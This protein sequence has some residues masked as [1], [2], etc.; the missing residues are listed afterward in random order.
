M[1]ESPEVL[2][3]GESDGH[4]ER[5]GHSLFFTVRFHAL[6]HSK[7]AS[8]GILLQAQCER[9]LKH[10]FRVGGASAFGIDGRADLAIQSM[11]QPIE[12]ADLSIVDEEPTSVDKGVAVASGNRRTRGGSYVGHE[13]WR[14]DV[15]GHASQILVIPGRPDIMKDTGRRTASV[16]ADPEAIS[17]DFKVRTF[18]VSRLIQNG[19]LRSH[20]N[21]F[22]GE[23][24]TTIREPSAH[25]KGLLG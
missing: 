21:G 15:G 8:D 5:L 3:V 24:M 22:Q 16:P 6:D 10:G 1:P 19:V 25:V 17:I 14:T 4:V 9:E 23:R 7:D 18:G 2:A 12:A 13:E 20:E 11:L